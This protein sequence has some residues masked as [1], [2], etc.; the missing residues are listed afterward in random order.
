[1]NYTTVFIYSVHFSFS[2]GYNMSDGDQADA[3]PRGFGF[4]ARVPSPAPAA[5]YDVEHYANLED[6]DFEYHMKHR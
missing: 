5:A 2:L 4:P 1:M 3:L 6:S